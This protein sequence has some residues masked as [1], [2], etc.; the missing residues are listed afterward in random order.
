MILGPLL[1]SLL[2]AYAQHTVIHTT[3][4]TTAGAQPTQSLTPTSTR[5]NM[6]EL[7]LD[8]ITEFGRALLDH[9]L[10][11]IALNV[12]LGCVCTAS[13]LGSNRE[14]SWSGGSYENDSDE[15]CFKHG[16]VHFAMWASQLL[17]EAS[18][19]ASAAAVI[20]GGMG[21]SHG[22]DTGAVVE[23][24][25]LL[26]DDSNLKSSVT[27]GAIPGTDLLA[28]SSTTIDESSS[29]AP[30]TTTTSTTISPAV[31]AHHLDW[32]TP[33]CRVWS[34]VLRSASMSFK[35]VAFSVLSELLS[36]LRHHALGGGGGLDS[37]DRKDQIDCSESDIRSFSD[38][39]NN[40]N[41]RH[42]T[43]LLRQCVAMLPVTRLH[44]MGAKRLWYEMEDFPVYSRFL[45][46]SE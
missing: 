12:R 13:G 9:T 32:V 16:N 40:E 46:V 35:H 19:E 15:D 34:H 2:R 22:R 10:S 26:V 24:Q 21:S 4:P 25:R 8:L 38:T 36:S 33:V 1:S 45:Q 37:S 39:T 11:L 41:F 7:S 28:H 6:G 3:L 29:S 18:S 20:A 17:L 5:V 44:L 42:F 23:G 27:N 30:P 31:L 43:A 14:P